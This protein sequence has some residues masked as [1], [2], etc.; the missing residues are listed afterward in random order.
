MDVVFLIPGRDDDLG[1]D[2]ICQGVLNGDAASNTSLQLIKGTLPTGTNVALSETPA[3]FGKVAS[4]LIPDQV[5]YTSTIIF[6]GQSY[7]SLFSILCTQI[8]INTNTVILEENEGFDVYLN[9]LR[10][11]QNTYNS[12]SDKENLFVD[13]EI[14]VFVGFKKKSN[15]AC[16][17]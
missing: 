5:A 14:T 17:V 9:V 7:G 6:K 10:R 13:D 3:P 1:T 11:N 16:I 2:P 12:G 15:P 8:T 4:P